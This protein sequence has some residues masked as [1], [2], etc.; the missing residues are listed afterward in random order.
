MPDSQGRS[1]SPPLV[2]GSSLLVIFS[3]L[4]LTVFA[5]LALS[6][7]QAGGRLGDAAAQA[8]SGYYQADCQAEEILARLRSGQV[9]EGVTAD[10]NAYLYACPISDTQEL[11]VEVQLDGANFTI[12]RWQAVSTADWQPDDTLTVWDG[13][14]P[15]PP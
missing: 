1:F 12:L 13:E 15:A 5:L 2:G 9:P 3:V 8:V 10:G 14:T 11:A 7:A 6:T 4:A